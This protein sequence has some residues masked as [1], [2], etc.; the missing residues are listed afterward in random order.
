M[1][2]P[3]DPPFNPPDPKFIDWLEEFVK[4]RA[5]ESA[6]DLELSREGV[7]AEVNFVR[8]LRHI[9]NKY[10]KPLKE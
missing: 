9:S 1:S 3:Q 6:A 8:F 10:N 7:A 2:L 4:N 5:W